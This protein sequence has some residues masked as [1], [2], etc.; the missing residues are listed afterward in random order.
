MWEGVTVGRNCDS[1]QLG[2]DRC[3]IGWTIV[4]IMEKVNRGLGRCDSC[5]PV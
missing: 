4:M 5:Q 3:V 2:I 1:P